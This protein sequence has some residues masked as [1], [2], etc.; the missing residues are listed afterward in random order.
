MPT[1]VQIVNMLSDHF[2]V[3]SYKVRGATIEAQIEEITWFHLTISIVDTGK[4]I[5]ECR[6]TEDDVDPIVT[7]HPTIDHY[8]HFLRHGP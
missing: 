6:V 4:I 8:A 5:D 7:V 3:H 1:T 2:L